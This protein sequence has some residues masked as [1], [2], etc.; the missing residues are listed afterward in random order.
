MYYLDRLRG[1]DGSEIYKTQRFGYPLQCKRGGGYKIRSGELI[2]VCMTSDFFL[3]EA[4]IWRDAAWQM[5]KE[6]S[7][8]R[9]FLLTKRP[10]RV[11]KCL[12]SEWG[13]GWDNIFFNVT[14]ENQHRAD[15]RIPILLNLPFKHKGIMTAPLIGPIEIDN[16]LGSGQ[17]E[18]IIAGGEN[19]DGARPCNFE[20]VKS[21][22]AQCAKHD[23][24]FYFIET[25]TVFVKDGKTYHIPGKRLQSEMAF[26]AQV[27]H[28]GKPIEFHLADPLGFEIE[29]EFLH[30]PFFKSSCEMCGSKCICNGCS[31]CGKCNH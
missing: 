17:I 12:P 6:R 19:Y 20:W 4:D 23:V 14:C 15:E 26:K 7:D 9:F 8:V 13:D 22:S 31:K 5:M 3:E 21:L 28:V 29:K 11:E 18:Q 30:K 10:E 16:F 25:G 24:S 1:N 2:R 27:N